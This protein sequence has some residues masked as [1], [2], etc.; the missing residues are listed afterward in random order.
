[1]FRI[2]FTV[3]LFTVPFVIVFL[4]TG[5]FTSNFLTSF[6]NYQEYTNGYEDYC[7]I[8]SIDDCTY[9]CVNII[10]YTLYSFEYSQEFYESKHYRVGQFAKCKGIQTY[11]LEEPT[12]FYYVETILMLATMTV[13]IIVS[14]IYCDSF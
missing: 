13:F 1:M 14:F 10:S 7:N 9:P 5:Y 8:T 6:K 2:I 4:L 12:L 3:L 11:Y